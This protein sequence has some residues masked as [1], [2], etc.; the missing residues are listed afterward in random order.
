MDFDTLLT[1]PLLAAAA[2]VGTY[3]ALVLAHKTSSAK[4]PG[5][6][7]GLMIGM[8]AYMAGLGLTGLGVPV[9]GTAAALTALGAFACLP[10]AMLLLI[11]WEWR[12]G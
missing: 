8:G 4:I 1:L 5:V 12:L 10:G 7:G 3:L 11:Q 9:M 2:S 6:T